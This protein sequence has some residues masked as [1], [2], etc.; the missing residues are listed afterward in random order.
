MYTAFITLRACARG[1]AIGSVRLS[2][3]STK[4]ISIMVVS[5]HDKIVGIREKLSSFCFLM[6]VTCHKCY[7]SCDHIGHA[8]IIDHT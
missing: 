4:V 7:K 8:Y 2:S 3:V 5:K 1:K 6:L